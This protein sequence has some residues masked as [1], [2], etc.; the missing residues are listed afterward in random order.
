[1]GGCAAASVDIS[2]SSSNG[3]TVSNVANPTLS[4][5]VYNA[6]SGVLTVTGTNFVK[7]NGSNNDIDVS[8]LSITGEGGNSYTL[9]SADVEVNSSTQFSVTLNA[10]DQ[11]NVGGLLN[12][13]GTSSDGGTT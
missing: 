7:E 10:A 13:N 6:T 8:K 3:I 2:D 11:L 9:T 5:A 4:S 12:K 1:M